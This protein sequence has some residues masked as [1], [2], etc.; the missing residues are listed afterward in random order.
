MVD[1]LRGPVLVAATI[2][3]G[4]VAGLF[5][6]FSC[7][8]MLGLRQSDD[9]TFVTAMQ[10]INVAILNGWFMASFVGALLLSILAV[11]LHLRG[12]LRAVLP[13]TIAAVV[14]YLVTFIVTGAI[15]VPLNDTLAAAGDPGGI[16]DLAAVRAQ[17]ESTWVQ[18][19]LVRAV[20]STLA[21]GC[22]TWALVVHG[23]LAAAVGRA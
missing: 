4:L 17:F 9:R 19:N 2:A 7:A 10:K 11:V 21:F 5:Y 1:M 20:T 23:R 12:D 3:M 14:L 8:V 22:L 13:W 15:N 16:P 6:A 18:W